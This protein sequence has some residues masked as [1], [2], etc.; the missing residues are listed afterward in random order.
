MSTILLIISIVLIL[1]GFIGCILPV[2]PG[3]PISYTGLLLI[4]FSEKWHF[5][6]RLL[7]ILALVTTIVTIL[8]YVVPVWGT[9]RFGGSKAGIK[10]ATAGLIV[11]LFFAPFGIIIGPF[12]GAVIGELFVRNDMHIAIR[13]GIGSFIGFL[14]GT[15]MKLAISG[16]I[17]FYF[18]REI[19]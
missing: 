9:K 5:S 11:G 1:V 7:I 3:P 17:A 12:I 15:G 19:F 16:V 8:D 18:F 14:M 2:L 13:S 4:H 6:T 10:G